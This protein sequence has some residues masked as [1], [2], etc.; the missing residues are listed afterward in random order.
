MTHAECTVVVEGTK[1]G[2]A[3]ENLKNRG[4]D[5]KD[6]QMGDLNVEEG[7]K[8]YVIKEVDSLKT[9]GALIMKDGNSMSA[10][11]FRMNKTDKLKEGN[12]KDTELDF[13]QRNG[14]YVT[15]LGKQE[16]GSHELKK[17]GSN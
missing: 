11:I 3:T 6:D 10:I 9:R 17:M 4:L 8:T 2:D 15:W 1:I 16:S 5:W 13:E 14:W 12:T 7:G